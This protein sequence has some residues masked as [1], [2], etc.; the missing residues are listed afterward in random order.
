MVVGSVQ[1]SGFVVYLS[2]RTSEITSQD[3]LWGGKCLPSH[4]KAL[5]RTGTIEID[6]ANAE[7]G[8]AWHMY[9]RI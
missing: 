7:G 2:S 8:C 9:T 1:A 3:I 6:T 4:D 5:L